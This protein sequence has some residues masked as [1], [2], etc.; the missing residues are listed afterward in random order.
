M[1]AARSLLFV[2]LLP[3]FGGCQ[4]LQSSP[5]A[6]STAGLTRLQGELSMVNGKLA[7]TP[8]QTNTSYR[9]NDTGSTSVLQE[10]AALAGPQHKVFADVRGRFPST[11]ASASGAPFDVQQLYRLER[12]TTACDNPNFQRLILR[13][14]GATPEWSVNVHSKGMVITR[15][16]QPDLALPYLEEQMGDGRFSLSSE[17]NNQHVELWVAPQR[18]VDPRQPSVQFMSAELRINGQVQRGCAYFGASRND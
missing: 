17:A 5:Q 15:A 2:A 3:L 7:F 13:A 10:A 14:S 8:C 9:V 18:C 12:S 1:R 16:G 4:L 6:P 11:T